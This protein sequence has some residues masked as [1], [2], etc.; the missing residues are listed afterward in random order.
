MF[1]RFALLMAA[2]LSIAVAADVRVV[3]EIAAKVN[4]LTGTPFNI[5]KLFFLDG[6]GVTQIYVSNPNAGIVSLRVIL[7]SR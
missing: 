6:Q 7:G 1:R 2:A 5:K 4:G 3:E